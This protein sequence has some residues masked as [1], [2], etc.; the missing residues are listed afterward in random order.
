MPNFSLSIFYPTAPLNWI[1]ILHYLF[2]LATIYM[3]ITSGEKTPILY[4]IVLG[5][6]ALSGG[7]SLYIDKVVLAPLF[8]FLIRVMMVAI[9]LVLAGWSPTENTR[10]AGVATAIVAA[11]VLAMTFLS[12]TIRVIADPRII[13]MGWCHR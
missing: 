13:N 1:S 3:L 9:P 10:S 2:L 4:I 6:Q 11:P 8:A 7:A 5:L 12:C